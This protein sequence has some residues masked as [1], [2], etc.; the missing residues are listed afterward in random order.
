MTLTGMGNLI[1]QSTDMKI[2]DLDIDYNG[3]SITN[4][5]QADW[6]VR[7]IK[8]ACAYCDKLIEHFNKQI[9][10]AIDVCARTDSFFRG[11]LLEYF[12]TLP[13]KES[14]TQRSYKL[15]S[16]K[17]VLKQPAPVF[18][19]DEQK[20]VDWLIKAG[21]EEFVRTVVFNHAKWADL[22]PLTICSERDVIFKETGEIIQGVTVETK[23][24]EFKID[25]N[26]GVDDGE[27]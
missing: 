6:A 2:D 10:E 9:E 23:E 15:M 21:K 25:F 16:G 12:L 22:K 26:G 3:W 17:L 27:S 20:L 14:K 1:D 8:E 7:K 4:D 11:K 5:G 24:A 18:K 13:V 19:R